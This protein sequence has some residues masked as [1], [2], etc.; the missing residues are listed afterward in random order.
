MAQFETETTESG[1]G[2]GRFKT[3]HW[4]VVL[5]ASCDDDTATRTALA[6]LCRAYWFPLYVF[7]RR[8]G[9]NPHD[10]QDLVQSFFARLLEKKY[11]K[12]ADP[13]KGRFRTF[14]LTALKGFLAN[15]WDKARRLK[16]GGGIQVVS[17]NEEDTEQRFRSEPSDD[18]SPEKAYERRWAMTLLQRAHDQLESE[19]RAEGKTAL[20]KTLE[21]FLSGEKSQKTSAEIGRDLGVSENVVNVT[22]HRLRKRYRQLLIEEI[23]QTVSG[24]GEIDEE[25]RELFA[26]LG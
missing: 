16:R 18:V 14:L 23:A 17:L 9:H 7:I 6:K 8:Q 24:P 2:D 21:P 25:I 3:T 5:Q 10:A 15:E 26:A 13:Q 22:V 20:F 12:D 19:L 1:A 4:S 11:V